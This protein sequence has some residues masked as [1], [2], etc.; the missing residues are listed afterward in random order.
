MIKLAFVTGTRKII[1]FEVN[2][3]FVNY[4]DDIWTN[5]IQIYPKDQ[6]M[7]ERL[8]RGGK[9]NLK[10]MAALLIDAN[11]GQDLKDYESCMGNEEKI[12]EFIKK[13]CKSKGLMQVGGY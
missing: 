6:Q 5:G 11:S 8:R 1:R 9:I 13:D 7:I 4:F 3:Q 2:K 10:L 12:A